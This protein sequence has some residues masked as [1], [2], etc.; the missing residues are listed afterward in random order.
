MFG[1]LSIDIY[2]FQ[3]PK[4]RGEIWKR[5]DFFFFG[6]FGCEEIKEEDGGG[7]KEEG[8]RWR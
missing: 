2:I 3:F 7:W 5:L 4:K 6:E 8:G 1:P